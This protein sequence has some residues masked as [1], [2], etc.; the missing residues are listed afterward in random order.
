[1]PADMREFLRSQGYLVTS[2]RN[3]LYAVRPSVSG[4]LLQARGSDGGVWVWTTGD[5]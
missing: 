2:R 5:G 1:M 3:L 4:D